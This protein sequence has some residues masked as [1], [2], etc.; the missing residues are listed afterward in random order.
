MQV[1]VFY[2]P[3]VLCDFRMLD[4]GYRVLCKGSTPVHFVQVSL[5]PGWTGSRSSVLFVDK[6]SVIDSR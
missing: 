2:L 3:L 1:S 5:S 4:L 6:F